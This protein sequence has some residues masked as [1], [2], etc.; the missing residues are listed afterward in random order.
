MSL[1]S[2]LLFNLSLSTVKVLLIQY[3]KKSFLIDNEQNK[4]NKNRKKPQKFLV[5]KFVLVYRK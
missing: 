5:D 3:V 1:Y 4:T 2:V